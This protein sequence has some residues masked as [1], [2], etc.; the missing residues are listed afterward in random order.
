[1]DAEQGNTRRVLLRG[2]RRRVWP[3]PP[4]AQPSLPLGLVC[5]LTMQSCRMA[6]QQRQLRSLVCICL[7]RRRSLREDFLRR[8][9]RQ[10]QCLL[11]T[12]RSMIQFRRS[13]AGGVIM[14]RSSD[15]RVDA[16]ASNAHS[17]ITHLYLM[18]RRRTELLNASIAQCLRG[19]C[20]FCRWLA[21]R[22]R[23]GRLRCSAG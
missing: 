6:A 4:R 2:A 23:G 20:R 1:M 13:D 15:W 8:A 19:R 10:Q 17:L 21:F 7:T 11:R 18:F 22:R 3:L 9:D 16:Y 14:R 12:T 5:T